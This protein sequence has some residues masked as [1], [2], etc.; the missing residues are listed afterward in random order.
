MFTGFFRNRRVQF[1]LGILA[2]F[3][4]VAIFG[5][6]LEMLSGHLYS[7][8][9]YAH[10]NTPPLVGGHVLGTTSAGKDVLAET[11]LGARGSITVGVLAGVIAVGLAAVI[12]VTSGFIGGVVDQVLNGLTNVVLTLPSFPVTLIAAGYLS[13]STAVGQP[14]I[15]LT[16]MAFLIGIFEWPGGARYLR[17]QTLSLRNRDFSMATKMLGESVWRQVLSEA[18]PHLIG[19]IS[20]MFLR[21]VIAGIM[22]EAGLNFLGVG[23]QGSVSWGTMIQEAQLNNAL[24]NGWWWWFLPPGVCIALVGTA[25]ALVNFGLD[26]VTNPQLRTANRSV[27]RRFQRQAAKVLAARKRVSA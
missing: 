1:G 13:A 24:L 25:T 12:G 23:T 8:V 15:G 4:V 26:E 10:L 6:Q 9:D 22:A 21:A 5:P 20:S 2:I 16:S 7:D 3:V 14:V 27:V 17:S 11:L 18:M 19:I